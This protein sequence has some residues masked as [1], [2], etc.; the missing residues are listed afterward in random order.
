MSF[1][2]EIYQSILADIKASK[3]P[4]AGIA[5][6]LV[7]LKNGGEMVYAIN[8]GNRL[9]EAYVGLKQKPEHVSFPKWHGISIDIA[10]LPSYGVDK[11]Y[12]RLLQLP[13]SEDYIF[14]LL[15]DD[16]YNTIINLQ[17]EDLYL[18]FVVKVLQKWKN[19]FQSMKEIVLSDERQEGLYGELCFLERCFRK[20]SIEDI[21][22]WV[23]GNKE[24]HDFYFSNNAVEVKTSS[25]N[26]PYSAQISS[27]YQLDLND[28][29]GR[30][31]LFFIALRK[32]KASGDKLPDIIQ[33]IRERLFFEPPLKFLFDEKLRQY[34]YLDEVAELYVTGFSIR[35]E[36]YFE[37]SNDFPKIIRSM[38]KE[39]ISK[40]TYR[41]MISQCMAYQIDESNVFATLEGDGTSVK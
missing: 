25:Q 33:R 40:V 30:L 13:Q 26:E 16:L 3:E 39:G 24:T 17:G 8:I 5:T 34:G 18:A 12:I 10:Q 2:N 28:I 1:T 7:S 38:F 9:R 23:G 37:V 6:R 32:S 21:R 27:E 14:D 29:D 4:Q 41:L 22:C 15:V 31:F 35:D 19:F 11:Y 20:R 36:F